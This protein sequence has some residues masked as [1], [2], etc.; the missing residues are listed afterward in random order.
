MQI[1]AIENTDQWLVESHG[2]GWGYLFTHKPTGRT[3]WLQD[4]DATAWRFEY[5]A[6]QDAYMNPDSAWHRRD[7]NACLAETINHYLED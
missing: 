6:M 3:G 4:D 2:N 7:W 1:I 5:E